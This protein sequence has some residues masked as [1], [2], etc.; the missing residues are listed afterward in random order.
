MFFILISVA[1]LEK[2]IM[3]IWNMQKINNLTLHFSTWKFGKIWRKFDI[4]FSV[5]KILALGKNIA[6]TLI[7]KWWIPNY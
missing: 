1:N 5:E 2:K 7:A 3:L 4:F 6:P